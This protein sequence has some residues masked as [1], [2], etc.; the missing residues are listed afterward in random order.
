MTLQLVR[1]VITQSCI[2]LAA[3]NSC[4]SHSPTTS[5]TA[6]I[7][8]PAIAG[9]LF[10]RG[11][12]LCDLGFAGLSFSA[13]KLALGSFMTGPS[14]SF[15]LRSIKSAAPPR[16]GRPNPL[17]KIIP[18][19]LRDDLHAGDRASDLDPSSKKPADREGVEGSKGSPADRLENRP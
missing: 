1:P 18:C 19:N 3:L 15:F 4:A 9:V 7:A 17:M 6:A 10:C 13:L 12:R 5:S 2:L 8:S 16:N 14:C 11:S